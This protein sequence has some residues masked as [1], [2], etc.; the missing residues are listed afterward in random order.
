M[1]KQMK[2][3]SFKKIGALLPWLWLAAGYVLDIWFQLVPGKWIVDS[4]LASEMM[5]TKILNQEGSI[6]SHSWYYSTELRVVNM[7]W[8]YRLGLLL[9][10][11]DWHLARTFGM[12]IALLV[13]IAAALLLAKGIGLGSLGPWMAGA[14]IWPF[15]MRYLVY[16]MYGGYYLI[17]M[18]LPML[19]LALV[20]C[21]IHAQNRRL[22][23]LCAVL[24]CLK[25]RK[26]PDGIS[27]TVPAGDDAPGGYGSEQ[28]WEN[29]LERCLPDLRDGD[30]AVSRCAVYHSGGDGWLCHQRKDPGKKL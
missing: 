4:D 2:G 10:P 13:F 22:K 26:G 3:S 19:T 23:V 17:H 1:D 20:F 18:L 12:A 8:F 25:R 29:Y 9:F 24:A 28:L 5:L 16:A 14:L 6:L 7:Q 27:G 11:D 30:A 21:S 15:G